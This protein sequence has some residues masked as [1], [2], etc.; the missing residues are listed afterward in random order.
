MLVFP[1]SI[2]LDLNQFLRE[3]KN[4]AITTGDQEAA[5]IEPMAGVFM[6]TR[7]LGH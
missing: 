1:T 7:P 4:L 5:P 6:S 3:S 2:K